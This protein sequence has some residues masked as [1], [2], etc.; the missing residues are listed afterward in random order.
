LR[1]QER[2]Y[3]MQKTLFFSYFDILLSLL[4]APE[5]PPWLLLTL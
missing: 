5:Q 4:T 2:I 3:K 1:P